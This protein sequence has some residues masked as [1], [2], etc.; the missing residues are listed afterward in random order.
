M[1]AVLMICDPAARMENFPRGIQ[2][3]NGNAW[4]AQQMPFGAP[5]MPGMPSWS[6]G[7]GKQRTPNICP[8][9]NQADFSKASVE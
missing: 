7:P 9:T 8:E 6:N 1:I 2:V 5:P 4:S 3:G